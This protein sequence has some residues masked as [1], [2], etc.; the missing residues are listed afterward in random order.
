LATDSLSSAA[1]KKVARRVSNP[2]ILVANGETETIIFM[3]PTVIN[4]SAST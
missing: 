1:A 2:N 4:L 3:A